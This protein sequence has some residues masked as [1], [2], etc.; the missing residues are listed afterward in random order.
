MS[1]WPGCVAS[2]LGSFLPGRLPSS[3]NRV[4]VQGPR[5]EGQAPD[6]RIAGGKPRLL[7]THPDGY[8]WLRSHSWRVMPHRKESTGWPRTLRSFCRYSSK[9]SPAFFIT[10]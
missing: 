5:G 9:R 1:L 3:F 4:R 10:R 6:K 2:P 7:A 8:G